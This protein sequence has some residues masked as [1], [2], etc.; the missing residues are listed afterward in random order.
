MSSG[1]QQALKAVA[2]GQQTAQ[3]AKDPYSIFK[4]QLERVK[5][6]LLPLMGNS[7]QNVYAFVRVVLTAVSNNPDLLVADRRSLLSACTR[8]AQD[9]N[10]PDGREAVLNVYNTKITRGYGRDKT[11]EWVKKVEYIPM[12]AGMVKALYAHPDIAMVDAAAVYENDKFTFRRGDDPKLE[13]EPTMEDDAGKVVCAYLVVKLKSGE[14]KREVMP[15]RDIEKVRAASKSGSG[16]NSPWT[17][18]YDQQAIKSVIKRGAKQLPRSNKFDQVEAADNE[19]L[20]FASNEGAGSVFTG[21]GGTPALEHN[22]SDVLDMP[23]TGTAEGVEAGKSAGANKAPQKAQ[24]NDE[25][26][27]PFRERI[28]AA[29]DRAQANAVLEDALALPQDLYATLE[30]L[31]NEKFAA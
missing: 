30:A 6:E 5:G 10:M 7:K 13:H 21:E 3:E 19:S 31:V 16:E 24:A 15:R 8:A 28:E 27:K 29:T 1:T 12:V 18:W 4:S 9:G 22:P 17:K 14:I 23:S 20:G 25:A 2:T 26:L 11:E